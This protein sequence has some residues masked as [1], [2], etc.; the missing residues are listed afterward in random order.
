MTKSAFDLVAAGKICYKCDLKMGIWDFLLL[1]KEVL[2]QNPGLC[3]NGGKYGLDSIIPQYKQNSAELQRLTSR[4]PWCAPDPQAAGPPRIA[5]PPPLSRPS[6]WP[7][8]HLG[9]CRRTHD[10]C[11]HPRHRRRC[12]LAQTS[13]TTVG[14]LRFH[15][16]LFLP[17][18]DAIRL[19]VPRP[20]LP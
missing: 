16:S 10:S 4:T 13:A 3:K 8:V 15:P 9:A 11:C 18:P 6:T 12:D 7:A 1:Y 14:Q 5:P 2:F 20:N 19:V 17:L